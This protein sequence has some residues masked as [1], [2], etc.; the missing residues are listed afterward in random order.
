MRSRFSWLAWIGLAAGLLATTFAS[1]EKPASAAGRGPKAAAK[2]A[3]LSF[4]RSGKGPAVVFLHGLGGDSSV[5]INVMQQLEATHTVLLVD[6]PGHGMS[7]P[8]PQ[9]L[10]LPA[11]A[12]QVAELIRAQH[13][14]PA[15]LVGHS[16]GG[17]LAGYVALA[18]PQALR[19]LVL[20]D[21]MFAPYPIAQVERDKLRFL[22]GRDEARA[23]RE[24]FGPL[25]RDA[26]QLDKI[27]ASARRVSGNTLIN[28]LDFA[29]ERDDLRTHVREISVPVHIMVTPLLTEG[30]SEPAR[31][32]LSLSH[33][34]FEGL[35]NLTYE[36]FPSARH[37]IFWDDPPGFQASLEK[38]LR[39]VE[40]PLQTPAP[41]LK[42]ARSGALA[43][44]GAGQ[45]A[46]S[47][48]RSG[49]TSAN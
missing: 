13:L 19:G 10:E 25:S 35:A 32:Q 43:K 1:A 40:P 11:V 2:A 22:L 3:P 14:A 36:Y 34:G 12:R 8:A 16:L 7:P 5:W 6:L 4:I 21:S 33:V 28:Y 39:R 23:L 42:P 26:A 15:V 38:F 47:F 44:P 30:Q 17:T 37:W 41:T 48:A 20:V 29:S 24:L 27:V 45:R 49:A 18:D 46:K 31:I 9:N